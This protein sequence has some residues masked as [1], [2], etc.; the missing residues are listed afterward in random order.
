MQAELNHASAPEYESDLKEYAGELWMSLADFEKHLWERKLSCELELQDRIT[1]FRRRID[2][3]K[4]TNSF[5]I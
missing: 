5:R 3:I 1:Q 4:K 2:Y